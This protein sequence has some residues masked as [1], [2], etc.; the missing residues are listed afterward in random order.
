MSQY[1]IQGESLTAIADAIRAK[2]DSSESMTP[3]AMAASI[4]ELEIG[5]TQIMDYKICDVRTGTFTVSSDTR[6][7]P[8]LTLWSHTYTPY[9]APSLFVYCKSGF[10]SAGSSNRVLV[11][12]LFLYESVKYGAMTSSVV[13]VKW[14]SGT[15]GG[16]GDGVSVS[17]DYAVVL[18]SEDKE[19]GTFTPTVVGSATGVIFKA[20]V[21][22]EWVAWRRKYDS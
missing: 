21:V 10:P 15:Y 12:S 2:V 16:S 11:A 18:S 19:A 3:E 13:P 8:T 5:L 17:Q 9:L 22:Y 1:L 7:G 6:Y 14:G 20:G 4:A